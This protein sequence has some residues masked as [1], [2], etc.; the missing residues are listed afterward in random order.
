MVMDMNQFTLLKERRFLPLFC[1]QFLGAFNDNIFKNAIV[2]LVVFF[3]SEQIGWQS[4]VLV[5]I[6]AGIFILPFFLFSAI[7]G[8]LADKYEKSMLIRRIKLL[9]ICIMLVAG[10]AFY[11]ESLALLMF[12]LFFMGTQ[13]TLFGPL[14]YSIIPQ[15]LAKN[16]LIGGNG[17][18]QMGTYLAI[19]LGT[20]LGGIIVLQPYG[21]TLISIT[22]LIMAMLGWLSSRYIQI[23]NPVEPTLIV[24]WN[25]IAQTVNIIRFA[26]NDRFVFI[27]I[28]A[29][30]W[31]WYIGASLLSIIPSYSK[32][33]LG[34]DEYLTIAM[35]TA[36]S[37]GIGAGSLLCEKL[38]RSG[39]I[40]WL[41]PIGA[42][43]ISIFIIDLALQDIA[44]TASIPPHIIV[45]L[46]LI[47]MFGGLYIVPLYT[48]LQQYSAETYRAR[49][50][51]GNN[52][53]NAL[54]MVMSAIATASLIKIGFLLAQVLI[55]IALLNIMVTATI[56]AK[57]PGFIKH[58]LKTIRG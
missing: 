48:L 36:F 20:I 32:E 53:L 34:G 14:K 43:G 38:S 33:V 17:L 18:I 3:F 12:V 47:G 55:I 42:I 52:V 13:S 58:L 29:I 15:H 6:A 51:A 26:S 46:V 40:M 57:E 39:K 54:F 45:D 11:L 9:E 22:V 8:Q 24:Q 44:T 2:I 27:V 1:T 50:I 10:I 19:L 49:I 5:N 16:E 31:F 21:T 30:S 28:I 37:I 7:A 56:F 4:G 23:A 25:L 41:V 35:L